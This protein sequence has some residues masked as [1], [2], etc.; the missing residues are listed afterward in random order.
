MSNIGSDESTFGRLGG[1]EH[2]LFRRSH[3]EYSSA[4]LDRRNLISTKRSLPTVAPLIFPPHSAASAFST[5]PDRDGR[6]L[7]N[8]VLRV[9]VCRRR[10]RREPRAPGLDSRRSARG[11][12]F[13]LRDT[14]L[15]FFLSIFSF[16]IDALCALGE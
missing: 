5:P 7:E 15:F 2:C 4:T 16:L 12:R 9:R 1:L 14:I 10:R 8:R 11:R 13:A 3:P 6:G